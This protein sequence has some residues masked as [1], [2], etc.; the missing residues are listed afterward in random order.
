MVND[1]ED[2]TLLCITRP[3]PQTHTMAPRRKSVS[4]SKTRDASVGTPRRGS[5]R[6][7]TSTA[8][9]IETPRSSRKA[10]SAAATP[11]STRARSKS[12][13]RKTAVETPKATRS[14]RATPSRRGKSVT[15]AEEPKKTVAT[16]TKSPKATT[17]T[18]SPKTRG[19]TEVAEKVQ[20]AK[21]SCLIKWCSSFK[22]VHPVCVITPIWLALALGTLACYFYRITSVIAPKISLLVYF[23]FLTIQSHIIG[24]VYYAVALVTSL[25]AHKSDHP[26]K[27]VVRAFFV[28]VL[29][30][31]VFVSVGFWSIYLYDPKL[32][33]AD[34]VDE[35]YTKEFNLFQHLY[36]TLIAL[37]ELARHF[38]VVRRSAK[39]GTPIAWPKPTPYIWVGVVY[40][41]F[42]GVI[43]EILFKKYSDVLPHVYPV[44]E[45]VPFNF[46]PAFFTAVGAFTIWPAFVVHFVAS[47]LI[48][49]AHTVRKSKRH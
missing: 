24:T 45:L 38:Y 33:F 27:S 32:I 19:K 31:T 16:P 5:R 15:P 22:K 37:V 21:P 17:P 6:S 4:P 3:P 47:K 49:K 40:G 42:Y 25:V 2:T 7:A 18:K 30:L 44:L 34:I 35:A 20:P 48:T 29:S 46:K 26:L 39:L 23:S 41:I 28:F 43:A 14:T 13:T 11:R 9:E 36:I 12:K 1:A 10:A 8:D